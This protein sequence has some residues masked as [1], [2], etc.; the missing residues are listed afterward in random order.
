MHPEYEETADLTRI[1]GG[2]EIWLGEAR[3]VGD[4]AEMAL[5]YGDN[6]R[7]DG[8]LDPKRINPT[9]YN[10]DGSTLKPAL[11]SEKDRHRF[12]FPCAGDGCYT[13]IVDLVPVIITQDAEGYHIGPKFL[14]KNV[15]YSGALVQMAK[16]ILFVGDAQPELKDPVHGILEIVPKK[17]EFSHGEEA[18]IRVFYGDKPLAEA[19]VKAVSEKEGT[20]VA[21]TKTDDQGWAKVLLTVPGD[22]M[23]KVLHRDPTKKVNDEFDMTNFVTTLVIETK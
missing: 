20:L 21:E 15:T 17:P 14:F 2:H 22:W 8:S 11:S 18:E 16:R 12:N 4:Q 7:P 13:A 3:L 1:M 5:L 23:F 19:E 6:M 10:P 9:V